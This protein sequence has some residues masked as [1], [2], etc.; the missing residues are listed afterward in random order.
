MNASCGAE[1][2]VGNG[3]SD[4]SCGVDGVRAMMAF[5]VPHRLRERSCTLVSLTM[6]GWWCVMA[7]I[8]T[9]WCQ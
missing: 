4:S 5:M 7:K 9:Q 8:G 3:D 6:R 2:P 1:A